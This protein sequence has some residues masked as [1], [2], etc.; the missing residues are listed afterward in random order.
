MKQKLSLLALV[1]VS[2]IFLSGCIFGGSSDDEMTD[3][4]SGSSV[5]GGSKMP[6]CSTELTKTVELE[7]EGT[8]GAQKDAFSF[9]YTEANKWTL[10]DNGNSI[11]LYS[12]DKTADDKVS[13][14]MIYNDGMAAVN[15]DQFADGT[16]SQIKNYPNGKILEDC[17]TTIN[18]H[19]ARKTVWTGEQGGFGAVK[20]TS[21]TV[22]GADS[23][24]SIEMSI[25]EKLYDK[26]APTGESIISTLKLLK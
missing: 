22:K 8:F 13:V 12:L 4:A 11:N 6:A 19:P 23:M 1:L 5:A 18:G 9:M 7:K 26:F 25:S 16:V 21:L 14:S 10:Q 15:L 17:S 20:A 24:V 2:S 3:D